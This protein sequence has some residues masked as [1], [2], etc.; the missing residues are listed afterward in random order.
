MT[1]QGLGNVTVGIGD[2]WWNAKN[3]CEAHGLKLASAADLG[4]ST[5]I[6]AVN[7]GYC[8]Y[9]VSE[10][11]NEDTGWLEGVFTGD[12]NYA[13]KTK[14]GQRMTLAEDDPYRDISDR[15]MDAF[16]IAGSEEDM[17]WL[18]DKTYSSGCAYYIDIALSYMTKGS[19]VNDTMRF[20]CVE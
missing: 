12:E 7:D 20:L 9:P 19:Y 3:W 14:E 5:E 8:D 2:S 4:F 1:I 13:C 15:L 17:I 18:R 6:T 10:W 16:G 11:Y